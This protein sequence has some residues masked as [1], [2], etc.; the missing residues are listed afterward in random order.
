M[1]RKKDSAHILS[2]IQS[3]PGVRQV[4]DY[5]LLRGAS[6]AY[7]T[8]LYADLARL[9]L[10]YERRRRNETQGERAERL[11]ALARRT[12]R[13][14]REWSRDAEAQW[15][16]VW[17]HLVDGGGGV[18]CDGVEVL[19]AKAGGLPTVGEYLEQLAQM[20]EREAA[21]ELGEPLFTR[22]PSLAAYV[23]CWCMLRLM[24]TGQYRRRPLM[25][26]ALLASAVLG[27]TVSAEAAKKYCD[28]LSR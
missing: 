12:R 28:R 4:T 16:T 10:E 21:R 24:E 1:T 26:A 27:H 22:R 3:D 5:L 11:R 2:R 23:T 25:H 8:R 9:P 20:L 6:D 15:W 17:P 19:R 13:L 7:I 18:R 14:S